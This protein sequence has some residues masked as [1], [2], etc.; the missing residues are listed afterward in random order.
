M[1]KGVRAKFSYYGPLRISPI[2]Y[3]NLIAVAVIGSNFLHYAYRATPFARGQEISIWFMY[4]VVG[5]AFLLWIF[6]R[7]ES[8]FTLTTHLIFS[9]LLALWVLAVGHHI[10]EGGGFNWTA[11]LTPVALVLIWIKP[12]GRKEAVKLTY[13]YASLL[14]ATIVLVHILDITGWRPYRAD[15]VTRW[16]PMIPGFTQGIRWEGMFGDPNL[17]GYIGAFLLTY[18]LTRPRWQMFIFGILGFLALLLSESRAAWLAAVVG[19]L[20]ALL[21]RAL[22]RRKNGQSGKLTI[23]AGIVSV[24]IPVVV[25]LILDPTMNGRTTIWEASFRLFDQEPIR[26]IG[27]TGYAKAAATGEMPSG[28]IDSH[29][30]VVDTLVRNG[31]F[32]GILASLAVV[33]ISIIVLKAFQSDRGQSAAIWFAFLVGAMTYTVVGWIYMDVQVMPLLLATL[34]A[35]TAIRTKGIPT[36]NGQSKIELS[37]D[38]K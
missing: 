22:A 19:A 30:I 5:M 21:G 29:N 34:L 35:D 36:L 12:P 27:N 16:L 37:T 38:L 11:F 25:F 31:I 26:G 10:S 28:N 24:L 2:S 7:R 33:L 20:L 4:A 15:I 23:S 1:S 18:G 9:I 3:L 17:G 32:S 6:S 14:A 8:Q 13:F